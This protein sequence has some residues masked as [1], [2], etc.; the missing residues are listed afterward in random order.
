MLTLAAAA[1][2]RA[3][4]AFFST[5]RVMSVKGHRVEG[6]QIVLLPRGGGEITCAHR[7]VTRIEP[8]EVPYPEPAT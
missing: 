1:P 4:L 6:D 5:G 8:D 3:E 2:A 7:L